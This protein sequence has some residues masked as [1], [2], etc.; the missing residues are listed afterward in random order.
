MILRRMAILAAMVALFWGISPL[1]AQN[2][3]SREKSKK[4][5]EEL[6]KK[7]LRKKA[8]LEQ[9]GRELRLKLSVLKNRVQ[10]FQ[11]ALKKNT[12]PSPLRRMCQVFDSLLR[13]LRRLGLLRKWRKWNP[14]WRGNKKRTKPSTKNFPP[15]VLAQRYVVQAMN[16]FSR[17]EYAKAVSLYTKAIQLVPGNGRL[18]FAR[19]NAYLKLRQYEKA[20]QDYRKALVLKPNYPDAY[21]NIAC[22]YALENKKKEALQ[23]LRKAIL[24]GFRDMDFARKDPDLKSLHTEKAFWELLKKRWK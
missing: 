22:S 24:H 12:Y 8:R 11:R 15:Q 10:A 1:M 6:Y 20:R 9:E 13:E 2:R 21:Y 4:S 5:T 23:W 7:L 16:A 19:G 17:G 3:Q 14:L 18:Y